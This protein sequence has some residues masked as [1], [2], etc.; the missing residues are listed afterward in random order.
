MAPAIS[1]VIVNWNRRALLHSCL[2]AVSHQTRP[3]A[4][5]I[6]VDNGSTD[7]SAAMVRAE[8]PHVRVLELR[9]NRGFAAA[10]NLGIRMARGAWI[11][12]LNNDTEPEPTWL[13]E[14]SRPLEQDAAV[15]FCASKLVRAD[16]SGRLDAAGDEFLTVGV[17]VKRGEGQPEGCYGQSD[18]VFGASAAAAL[19]RRELFE[20]VGLFDEAFTPAYHED[21]DLNFRAQLLG[22]QCRYVPTAEVRHR[23]SATL[24]RQDPGVLYLRARNSWYVLVKNLP[25]RLWMRYGVEIVVYHMAVAGYY[26][27]VRPR[28]AKYLHGWLAAL[29]MLPRLLAQRREIQRR[30]RLRASGVREV[31]TEV[32]VWGALWQ[33][34]CR[35]HGN[36]NGRSVRVNSRPE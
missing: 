22:Y 23:V 11:A 34:W 31:L 16:G 18:E 10:N 15:G 9:E 13:E 5:V 8:F 33:Q 32:G 30:S 35:R 12:L 29:T 26:L 36:R 17:A 20:D 2:R 21:T 19:Y 25:A 1:V 28:G 14:L 6:V 24:G 3:A 4:E 27:L 7:G